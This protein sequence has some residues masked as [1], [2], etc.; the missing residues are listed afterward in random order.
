MKRTVAIGKQNFA[1]IGDWQKTTFLVTLT[2]GKREC[3]FFGWLE[4]LSGLG[5]CF[6]YS[7]KE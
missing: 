2:E 6:Q 3:L 7:D 4:H 5:G 1:S